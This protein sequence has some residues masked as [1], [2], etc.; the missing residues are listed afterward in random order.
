[1]EGILVEYWRESIIR[2]SEERIVGDISRILEGIVV[3]YWSPDNS[4]IS[5]GI[6]Y[7]ILEGILEE[8]WSGS[9]S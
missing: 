5:E 8:Y 1:M 9:I 7:R 6:S 4:R 3:E 2:I